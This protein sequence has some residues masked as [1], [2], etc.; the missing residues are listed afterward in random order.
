MTLVRLD[1]IITATVDRFEDSISSSGTDHK[2]QE[3]GTLD[4]GKMYSNDS[5]MSLKVI[6][7]EDLSIC[8]I[9]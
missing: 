4:R 8:C 2:G 5:K 3:S 7:N 9:K 1:A 6:S